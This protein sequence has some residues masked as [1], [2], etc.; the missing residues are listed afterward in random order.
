MGLVTHPWAG[1][2]V[3]V[4]CCGRTLETTVVKKNNLNPYWDEELSFDGT[5]EDIQGS[6]SLEVWD[7]NRLSD[8]FLG[9]CLFDLETVH[10][11]AP[12]KDFFRAWITLLDTTGKRQ[13]SQGLLCISVTILLPGD[14]FPS[15][16]ES[17]GAANLHAPGSENSLDGTEQ[18]DDTHSNNLDNILESDLHPYYLY[19][20]VY[21]AEDLPRNQLQHGLRVSANW[22]GAAV[23]AVERASDIKSTLSTDLR[24]QGKGPSMHREKTQQ[25]YRCTKKTRVTLDAPKNSRTAAHMQSGEILTVLE[26]R[27]VK[28]MFRMRGE[29]GWVTMN[30]ADWQPMLQGDVPEP[31]QLEPDSA[32]QNILADAAS[33]RNQQQ[34]VGVMQK[35]GPKKGFQ[36][37]SFVLEN[38]QLMYSKQNKNRTIDLRQSRWVRTA[39]LGEAGLKTTSL[40]RGDNIKSDRMCIVLDTPQAKR[41]QEVLILLPPDQG[42]TELWYQLMREEVP[43]S[44]FGPKMDFTEYI[45]IKPAKLRLDA[46]LQ[47]KLL[48][49]GNALKK[50]SMVTVLETRIVNGVNRIRCA[51]GWL[52]LLG[53]HSGEQLLEGCDGAGQVIQEAKRAKRSHGTN[54]VQTAK[55]GVGK[56]HE[57]RMRNLSSDKKWEECFVVLDDRRLEY[58]KVKDVRA[59][60]KM[61]VKSQSDVLAVDKPEPEPELGLGTR[62]EPDASTGPNGPLVLA[63]DKLGDLLE[64]L[65]QKLDVEGVKTAKTKMGSSDT[66]QI[67]FADFDR[68]WWQNVVPAEC[69]ALAK[70]FKTMDLQQSRWVKTSSKREA[71]GTRNET[72]DRLCIVV[73]TPNS[74]LDLVLLPDCQEQTELWYQRMRAVV[75]TKP[76]LQLQKTLRLMVVIQ[77]NNH[78]LPTSDAVHLKLSEVVSAVCTV[79]LII[80]TSDQRDMEVLGM[81]LS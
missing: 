68:W 53:K 77:D 26:T 22:G 14:E 32:G 67:A 30:S 11:K 55:D 43:S 78:G 52:S 46:S 7:W 37:H 70:P 56:R 24:P 36:Q 34:H 5:L 35:W 16:Q 18:T 51:R 60:F 61:L 74:Q 57:A 19:L 48:G 49:N 33:L 63:A 17:V 62:P 72:A 75:P 73:D 66:G 50:G 13:G 76:P 9:G 42:K 15:R 27:T 40:M 4:A 25:Y 20:N 54:P 65:G 69:R 3:R 2:Y 81:L 12:H 47:S 64:R 10:K 79:Q 29:Q 58:Y 44:N 31:E 71:N 38:G 1:R 59:V 45:C 39:S 8:K 6:L 21:V 28:G 41:H 23:E 80:F